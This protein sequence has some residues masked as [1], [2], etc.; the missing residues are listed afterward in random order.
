MDTDGFN[1]GI[2]SMIA[3]LGSITKMLGL[4]FSTVALVKFGKEA[5]GVASDLAEVDNVVSKAFGN[6][7]NEMDDLAASSIKNLGMSRLMAYQTGSTFM[8][9]G[10]SMLDSSENAKNMALSLTKLTANMASFFNVSQDL[11]SIALK[12]IYTGETETL[13]QYGV[14]MTE[15]NLKQFAQEQGIKKSYAAMTQ[16]EK[17]MLRYQYVMSQLSYIG[18][19]FIDTQDSWANQTRI[20]SEQWKEFLGIVGNGL[21]AVLTPVVKGL[22][23][24]VAALIDVGNTI[25]SILSSVFGIQMQQMSTTASAAESVAG[26]YS[27]AADSM[28]DYADATTKAGKAAKGALASFDDLNVLQQDNSGSG[29]SSGGGAA[30]TMEPIETGEQESALD[31]VQ[32]K[33]EEFFNYLTKLK[34]D[35]LNGFQSSW[36]KL[37][38]SSQLARIKDSAEMVK[39]ALLNIFTD[40][41]VLGAAD[42]FVQAVMTSLGRMSASV[43]SI[44][45]TLASNFLGGLATYLENNT[46]TIKQYIIHMFDIGADIADVLADGLDA[47][48]N[49]FSVWGEENGQTITAN[50]LQIIGDVFM[51]ATTLIADEVDDLLHLII[52]PFVDNQEGFKTAFDG[53]LSVIA[54]FATTLSNWV[55][56]ITTGITSLYD[57][58]IHPFVE[59]VKDGVSELIEKFLEFWNTYMQP[60][61]EEWAAMFNDTY[62]NYIKPVIDEIIEIVGMVID[63]LRLLWENVLQPLIGWV[64]ENIL[65][66]I[67]P[68]LQK[69]GD[70]V[71]STV[72]GILVVIRLVLTVIKTVIT[73]IKKV[74]ETDW[75]EVFNNAKQAA[76]DFI[77]NIITMFENMV[78]RVIDGINALING[79]NSIGFDMPDWLG[80]GS[81]HPSIPNIP[82]ANIPRLANGGITVGRTYAEIGEAGREAVLPLEN[83]TGW[84]DD[85]ADKL[86][87]RMPEYNAPTEVAL[88]MDGKEVARAQVPYL[89]AEE[90]R[91]GIAP[92]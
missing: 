6:M 27:D 70:K 45:A 84:M 4:T 54:K 28:D 40:K 17:V 57:E 63:V 56:Q 62:E 68:I 58:H 92:A 39:N 11:A 59:S 87:S 61:L 14:V 89:H 31:Q 91:L 20:L 5:I 37:D 47:L 8:S 13:K 43:L 53:L 46:E 71:K 12:S 90:V 2:K 36:G 32:S 72:D 3:S 50:I 74:F 65:P 26:G 9:M 29:S 78:N 64:I 1:H 48:A 41:N 81:W 55:N 38:I 21:I 30:V 66:I 86:V 80:G 25:S 34:D 51:A 24:I 83:N 35:F 22:N 85:L 49:V 76:K 23:T 69:M 10:K 73:G 75:V 7:R 16:S 79:F 18:D 15:V 44:G 77:N 82:R 88:V 67:L 19:D 52:D 33:Y 42:R 60:I